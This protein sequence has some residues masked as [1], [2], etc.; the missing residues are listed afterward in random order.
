MPSRTQYRFIGDNVILSLFEHLGGGKKKNIT[1]HKSNTDYLKYINTQINN[2]KYRFVL[3][4]TLDEDNHIVYSFLQVTDYP[5]RNAKCLFGSIHGNVFYISEISKNKKCSFPILERYIAKR[6]IEQLIKVLKAEEPYV[7]KI[8]LID[9]TGID[10]NGNGYNISDIHTLKHGIPYYYEI[11]FR[12]MQNADDRI[13]KH[14][15]NILM[16]S[17]FN[18]DSVQNCPSELQNG[19]PLIEAMNYLYTN[20]YDIF[21]K[22]IRHIIDYY[23]IKKSV[24]IMYEKKIY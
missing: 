18:R 21:M 23:D 15:Y 9:M 4:K 22:N 13:L 11:G 3:R 24:A 19:I 1:Y 7:E 16:N 5:L 8:Q 12:P 14:N 17:K 10:Y 2:E 20:Y 6:M